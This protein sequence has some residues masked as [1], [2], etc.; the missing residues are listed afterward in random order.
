VG[1]QGS[2][3]RVWARAGSRPR[4]PRDRRYTWAYIF[5]AACPERG[6]GAA[7]VMPFA[8]TFALNTHLA[9]I[10]RQVA[11]G[12]HAA[13]VLDGAGYHTANAVDVPANIT[14]IPLPPYSPE[15]NAAENIWEWLRKNKLAN[16]VHET[17]DD[18]VEACCSA[19]R[20][21]VEEPDIVR[22]VTRRSWATVSV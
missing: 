14:L 19:W 13:V 22:S 18:I 11:E 7:V 20:D 4:A 21:F 12:A 15:L 17:Y 3:T 9:E 1:Q 2:L 16:R 10:S 6:V 5:G 8:D